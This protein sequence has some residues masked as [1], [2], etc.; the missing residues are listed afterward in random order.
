MS[1][2]S[3]KSR[4][5]RK[6]KGEPE[7]EPAATG[8][9]LDRFVGYWLRFD[10]FGW[11][12]LGVTLCALGLLTLFGL[13]GLTAGSFVSPWTALLLRWVGWGSYPL[14][15]VFL[16]LGVVALLRRTG[17]VRAFNLGQVLAVE[18]FLFSLLA[19]LSIL[20]GRSL[21]RAEAGLDGG[22]IG[23][24]LAELT[25]S[26]LPPP[27][28]TVVF[29]GL[30]ALFAWGS[31]GLSQWLRRRMLAWVEAGPPQA[32]A[33]SDAG[34]PAPEPFPAEAGAAESPQARPRRG[35]HRAEPEEPAAEPAGLVVERPA[36]LPPLT[37]LNEERTA[38]QDSEQI[39]SIGLS[40]VKTLAEFGVPSKV[41]GY[42]VGPTVTQYAIEPGYIERPAPDGEVIRQ[43]VR[44]SQISALSRDLARA[45]AAERLRIE[46]PVPGHSYVGVEVPNLY[47]TMVRLRPVLESEAFRRLSSPLAIALGKDVSGQPM[48]A[49]LGKMP[50]LLVAGTTGSGKSVCIAAIATCLMMNNSPADLR[51]AMLDPKMVELV[52]FNGLP[53]LLG[54]VETKLDRMLGVLQWAIHEMDRRYRLLEDARS[55][56]IETYNRKLLRR[57]QP[58]LPRIVILIDE[59]ADLMMSAPD[60]TEHNLV[61]LAQMARA[62]GIHL[63]VATQR[64]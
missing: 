28:G 1:A 39:K 36:D 57:K 54:K 4:S 53:H 22:V 43:K 7:Q 56:D 11:D 44:V 6:P 61:R 30:L 58:T 29:I 25:A 19:L 35:K 50:H 41:V 40:I 55:R 52:R 16:Y 60:Q 2:S 20:S 10:R 42:R 37:L 5:S 15:V 33:F 51:L 49:D 48:V 18:G 63:V 34:D 47:T 64:P 27:V 62:T 8:E 26:F 46:A 59:L 12:F 31:L 45:L 21:D 3:T 17:R 13:F 32:P 38:E 9:W 24:G 14:A 23:W